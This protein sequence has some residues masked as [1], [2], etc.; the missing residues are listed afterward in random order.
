MT[1]RVEYL[2]FEIGPGGYRALENALPAMDKV[3]A[4]KDKKKDTEVY[5][6]D[7]LLPWIY[8]TSGRNS[9]TFIHDDS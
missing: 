3:P 5:W 9:T 4:P 7:K 2:G 1:T 8:T 6:N